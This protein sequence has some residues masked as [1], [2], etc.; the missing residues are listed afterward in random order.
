MGEQA[1][2][3]K[4]GGESPNKTT[5]GPDLRE[6]QNTDEAGPSANCRR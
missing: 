6:G 3:R 5:G 4:T 2:P 1:A